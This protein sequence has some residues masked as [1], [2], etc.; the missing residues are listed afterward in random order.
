M[1]TIST[2]QLRTILWHG[3]VVHGGMAV[4]CMMA[5]LCG[6]WWHS[7]VVWWHG[8]VVCGGMAMWCMV[9]RLCGVCMM[10]L[11]CGVCMMALL[12]GV[13]WHGCVVHDG[14][15]VWLYDG[16]ITLGQP[17]IGLSPVGGRD[18]WG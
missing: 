3:C 7:Y 1:S 14:T 5:R 2:P 13:W 17:V 6:L 15:A 4:W 8:Y 10:A 11:L 18:I 9:A 12:C 16:K